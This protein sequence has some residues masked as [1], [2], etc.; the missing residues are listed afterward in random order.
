MR[1]NED[2]IQKGIGVALTVIGIVI[3]IYY[4]NG[5]GRISF[6][7]HG[8]SMVNNGV[9]IS[10]KVSPIQKV[11]ALST[12]GK[13]YSYKWEVDV[14]NTGTV[15]WE[16]AWVITRLGVKDSTVSTCSAS[17]VVGSYYCEKCSQGQDTDACRIDINSW[18]FAYSLDGSNWHNGCPSGDKWGNTCHLDLKKLGIIPSP[19]KTVK[20]Y[21]KLTPPTSAEDGKYPLITDGRIYVNGVT[22]SIKGSYD[23]LTVGNISGGINL[24]ILGALS[25]ISGLGL[26]IWSILK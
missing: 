26:I 16:D 8:L 4:T 20:V 23:Y 22:Y 3:M 19:G 14:S 15:D 12:V 5:F 9:G 11:Q 10:M 2:T 13:G 17:G 6:S 25:I 18:G 7:T 1:L 24:Q 21:F